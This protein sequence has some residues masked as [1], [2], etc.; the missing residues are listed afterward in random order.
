MHLR[1][2]AANPTL[3]PNAAANSADAP[4]SGNEKK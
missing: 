3:K 4:V 1:L 2:F